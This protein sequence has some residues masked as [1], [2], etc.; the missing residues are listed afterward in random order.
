M[1]DRLP[2]HELIIDNFAGGGG[3]SSGIEEALQRPVDH[4]INHDPEAL[5]MHRI[6]HPRTVHH[7]ESVWD[8][9][10][11]TLAGRARPN[12]GFGWFSPDCTH[13]S[14]A[15]GGKPVDKKIRG[16][17][18][19]ILRWA[20]VRTRVITMENVVEIQTYGPLRH[21]SRHRP[22]CLCGRPCGT[23]D[24]AHRGRTWQ[25]FLDALGPGLAPDHPDLPEMLRL[26]NHTITKAQLVQ[27]FG[28]QVEVK[29]IR[30]CDFGAP[31]IR[32]RLYLIARCDGRP[33]VW[34]E[35]THADPA[36][37]GTAL[38]A[39]R[40]H[41]TIAECID[42]DRPCP[43]IFLTARQARKANCR[44]PLKRATL[45]RIA[46][47]VDRF[48][49]KAEQP[50]IINL[51]HH[52]SERVQP[53]DEPSKTLTAARRGEKALVDAQLAPLIGDANRPR[54]DAAAS[55]NQP[56]RTLCAGVKGGHFQLTSATLVQTGYGERKGQKPRVPGLHKPLGTA[57]A[58][59]V[60]HA[61]VT[62]HLMKF[63]GDSAGASLDKP[64][65]TV[66]ANSHI[67][68][69]GGAAP[70]GLCSASLMVNTT[71]HPG[72]AVTQPSPTIPTG[73]HHALVAAGMVKLRGDPATHPGCA[74]D[75]PAH[76]ASAGGQ[77]HAVSACYLAQHNGGFNKMPGHPATAPASTLSS[78][79]SQQQVVAASLSTYYGSPHD[80]G[81]GVAS[82]MRT[83]TTK[84]RFSLTESHAV[85]P[86]MTPEQVAGAHRVARFLRRFGV[87]FEGEFAT[88]AG[89]VIFDIGIGMRMLTAREL[90]RAQGFRESYVI[91]RAWLVDPHT[92]AVV[93]KRLS[94]E[95]QIRMCGN[96]VCPPVAAALV[97]ANVPELIARRVD[98]RARYLPSLPHRP[99]PAVAPLWNSL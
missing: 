86:A 36:Q 60:K 40:P 26:L 81:Q 14:K 67:K 27:G 96:S 2:L 82:P 23:P 1:I 74:I 3:G 53:I 88:V 48:V 29:E 99:I 63:Q 43:S 9:N 31:T 65:P 33:I 37:V 4:A 17:V 47:G 70:I 42:W 98:Y 75:Q 12:F 44:R 50:F 58:G 97:R 28:Y 76:T 32:N 77:H 25:A 41:R 13:F 59:G 6:N 93:E 8:I 34:P 69:P 54:R 95:A 68:K 18:L 20:A 57:V 24:K 91:D 72:A 90:F 64:G 19:V 15:K 85:S 73:G 66:T 49:L 56:L 87:K 80:D 7:C 62:A 83:A 22:D 55:A 45:R 94:K 84:E 89:F 92:G 10:P 71:R 21:H 61:L 30:A 35:P 79:G 11:A 5:G 39:V 16:L 52:G 46:A 51:T 78:R 38:R